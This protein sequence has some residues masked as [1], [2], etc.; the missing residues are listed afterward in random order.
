MNSAL[1]AV[2][3][4]LIWFICLVAITI[5]VAMYILRSFA[6]RKVL[7][8]YNYRKTW[9]AFIPYAQYYAIADAAAEGKPTMKFFSADCPV[10]WFKFW[11]IITTAGSFVPFIGPTAVFV[12]RMF[13]L[14]FVYRTIYARCEKR[15]LGSRTA[16]GFVSSFIELIPI[17]KFL[18]YNGDPVAPAEKPGKAPEPVRLI[19][20]VPVVPEEKAPIATPV[21]TPVIVPAPAA[22]EVSTPAVSAPVQKIPESETPVSDDKPLPSD[23]P[24]DIPSKTPEEVSEETSAE[25][26]QEEAVR[27]QDTPGTASAPSACP[28]C[29]HVNLPGSLFCT[30]CGKKLTET[31]IYL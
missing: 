27:L 26:G 22:P 15:T 16:L 14:G 29:G 21:Y 28:N 31:V 2:L 7:R 12:F 25:A 3:F 11:Y 19:D 5:A 10:W 6:F 30:N 20:A 24:E 8:K 9:M 17:I 23:Q 1:F 18:H 13:F 4:L